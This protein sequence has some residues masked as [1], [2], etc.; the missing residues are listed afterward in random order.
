MGYLSE[1]ES[2]FDSIQNNSARNLSQEQL[3]KNFLAFMAQE[4]GHDEGYYC[5]KFDSKSRDYTNF[6]EYIYKHYM[7][8]NRDLRMEYEK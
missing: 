6:N 1:L 7:G 8:L 2:F 4:Y 3:V 5:K